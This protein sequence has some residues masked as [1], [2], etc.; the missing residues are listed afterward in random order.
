MNNNTELIPAES[1]NSAPARNLAPLVMVFALLAAMA[2]FFVQ[3]VRLNML[4]HFYL[5]GLGA[6]L[7]FLFLLVALLCWKP[8]K[9]LRL[10]LG[11]F[12]TLLLSA[13]CI[14]GTLYTSKAFSTIRQIIRR[15]EAETI[16]MGIYVLKD[17]PITLQDL[18]DIP[19]GR[20]VSVDR[21]ETDTV[22]KQLGSKLGSTPSSLRY[23]R[24]VEMIGA[25]LGGQV[26][27]IVMSNNLIMAMSTNMGSFSLDMVRR[28]D[29]YEVVKSSP[30]GGEEMPAKEIG[31]FLL[32]ISGI[33]DRDYLAAH[34]LTDVNILAAVNP[35]T[36]QIL[37]V[38][39]PRDYF[40]HTPVSGEER[41]K[42]THAGLYGVDVSIGA[43]NMLYDLKIDY[44]FRIDF[45]GFKTIIDALGGVDVYSDQT[46]TVEDITFQEGMNHMSGYRA[47][48]FSRT[49]YG[50]AGGDRARGVHQMA[51]IQAVLKKMMSSEL[52]KN[53][54]PLMNALS[55]SFET[56]VPYDTISGL[57]Q[58][59]LAEGGGWDLK[60]FSVTGADASSATFT[61]PDVAY[62]MEPDPALVAAARQF[63]Q[64]VLDG[65]AIDL[66]Q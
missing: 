36:R 13:G 63:L 66:P 6:A 14:F 25:L 49:R 48:L 7:V 1:Q 44:F 23:S 10:G 64:D 8:G 38:N 34:S 9:K 4:P 30:P 45:A 59:Q 40:V 28:L 27:A 51:V 17:D 29:S 53:F 21:E 20:L 47:L 2:T 16:Q 5:L 15:S 11:I 65:K 61:F 12:L 60:T 39:T 46:F 24:P 33:D 42:L 62:V 43:L 32:Y 52:L 31:P 58:R 54:F 22:L 37:L 18:K 19:L 56:T 26:R 55:G 50:L 3:V 35:A 41:D 57:V